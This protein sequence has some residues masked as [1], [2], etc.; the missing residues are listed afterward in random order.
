MK[1]ASEVMERPAGDIT[2]R[3]RRERRGKERGNQY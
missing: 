3:R 2:G 1:M